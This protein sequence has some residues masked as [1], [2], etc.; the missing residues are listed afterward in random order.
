MENG[1][2]KLKINILGIEFTRKN[3][4][5]PQQIFRFPLSVISVFRHAWVNVIRPRRNA[6]F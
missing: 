4:L 5:C 6:A 1:K 3:W 2:W